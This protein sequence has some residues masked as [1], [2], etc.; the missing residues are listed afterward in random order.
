MQKAGKQQ[1]KS[2][3]QCS[4]TG[5]AGWCEREWE[6][7][8]SEGSAPHLLA[9]GC[10]D[11]WQIAAAFSDS[12]VKLKGKLSITLTIKGLKNVQQQVPCCS[13]PCAPR[14][15]PGRT[16]SKLVSLPVVPLSF[17]SFL[18]HQTLA[19]ERSTPTAQNN[20]RCN[21][22]FGELLLLWKTLAERTS[23]HTNIHFLSGSSWS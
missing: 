17:V 14:K 18:P 8:L 6:W 2:A 20:Y 7:V 10:K 12:F 21:S 4:K 15:M 16:V 1:Q 23:C 22:H 9:C 11:R 5:K 13:V 19:P 3:T